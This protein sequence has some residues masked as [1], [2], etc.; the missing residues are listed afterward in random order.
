MYVVQSK[1]RQMR[2][3]AVS[4]PII[5][6]LKKNDFAPR[7]TNRFNFANYCKRVKKEANLPAEVEL[8]PH[9]GRRS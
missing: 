6:E 3:V 2:K 7:Q 8:T 1:N 5:Q 9:T 4:E